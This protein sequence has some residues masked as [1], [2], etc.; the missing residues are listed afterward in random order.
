MEPT[1]SLRRAVGVTMAL[2]ALGTILA[3]VKATPATAAQ[4]DCTLTVSGPFFYAGLVSPNVEVACGSVRKSIRVDA[5]LSQDGVQVAAES[6]TC[7]QASR[8]IL[9]LASDGIFVFDVPGNQHWCGTGSGTI[10]GKG[11]QVLPPARSCESDGF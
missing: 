4:N 3:V 8:C 5:T 11:G 2:L 7:H 1:I 6:R 9:G 10:S